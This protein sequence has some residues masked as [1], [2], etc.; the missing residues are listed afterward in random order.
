VFKG[1]VAKGLPIIVL[2]DA[3]SAS[4]PRSSP[5]RFRIRTAR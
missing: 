5:A 1:D 3:G 4:P 2:V